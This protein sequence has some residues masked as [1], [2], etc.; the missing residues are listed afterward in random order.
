VRAKTYLAQLCSFFRKATFAFATF[1][2]SANARDAREA[3]VYL[4]FSKK[5]FCKL[6]KQNL[7]VA[8]KFRLYHHLSFLNAMKEFGV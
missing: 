1:A 6:D 5:R 8:I 7:Y 3:K 4:F 2:L